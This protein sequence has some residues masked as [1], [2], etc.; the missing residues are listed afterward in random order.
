MF[1]NN[2]KDTEKSGEKLLEQIST[3]NFISNANE[4]L[5][6]NALKNAP[7]EHSLNNIRVLHYR[8][9]LCKLAVGTEDFRTYVKDH[10]LGFAIL[11]CRHTESISEEPSLLKRGSLTGSLQSMYSIGRDSYETDYST[12][13]GASHLSYMESE[14]QFVSAQYQATCAKTCT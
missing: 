14:A 2:W 9:P 8:E 7:E 11:H 10:L 5:S 1:T 3:A 4:F 12:N 13:L 6:R